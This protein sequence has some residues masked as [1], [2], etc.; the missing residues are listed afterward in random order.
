MSLFSTAQVD[1]ICRTLRDCG[2]QAVSMA[3]TKFQVYEKGKHDYVTDVDRALDQRLSGAIAHLFPVDGVISEENPASRDRFS[4]P[5]DPTQRLWLIDPLDGTEDFIEGKLH[6]AIMLGALEDGVPQ[7]GWVYAP[8]FQQLYWGGMGI[9][10]FAGMGNDPP[11]LLP[12]P[13]YS[14]PSDRCTILIGMKDQHHFGAAIAQQI[15][16]VQFYSIGSFGL[17]VMEVVL[18]RADLYVYFNRK[19]KL[20]DTVGPLAIARAAGLECCDP[21][22]HPIRFTRDAVDLTTLAHH[23]PIFVGY[24]EKMARWRSTVQKAVMPLLL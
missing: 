4:T 1:E 7:A 23:Q 24:P 19:V 5:S 6:Y 12:L 20:W 14:S 3:Q 21:D 17:K 13:S 2:D 18:G 11:R 15:P 9:G 10:V 22:G 16:T 8:A